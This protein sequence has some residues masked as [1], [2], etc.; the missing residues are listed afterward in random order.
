MNPGINPYYRVGYIKDDYETFTDI[1]LVT[2]RYSEY[3]IVTAGYDFVFGRYINLRIYDINDLFSFSGPQNLCHVFSLG[4]SPIP[5]WHSSDV[6]L[7]DI[8]G[9]TFSTVSHRSKNATGYIPYKDSSIIHLA[10]YD[11]NSLLA[12]SVYSLVANYEVPLGIAPF[13]KM[14]QFIC[15]YKTNRIAFLHT[16]RNTTSSSYLSEYFDINLATLSTAGSFWAYNNPSTQQY[17]LSLYNSNN[18]Y[19]L[20]GHDLSNPTLLKFQMNTF[21]YLSGCATKLT[22]E[23]EKK[24]NIGSANFKREFVYGNKQ[25][26]TLTLNARRIDLPM[27]IECAQ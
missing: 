11:I 26:T 21:G 13:R 9:N 14:E 27:Y 23:Y 22:Y 17:G 19:I 4:P 12:N 1:K 15:S 16:Y 18:C 6:L 5:E 7:S 8:P 20:S 24:E 3:Y 25:S 2:N 10:F